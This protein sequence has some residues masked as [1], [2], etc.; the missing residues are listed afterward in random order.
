MPLNSER[1][2]YLTPFS[3]NFYLRLSKIERWWCFK[4]FTV[5]LTLLCIIYLY[6]FRSIKLSLKTQFEIEFLPPNNSG[7]KVLE[8][9]T[10]NG[11]TNQ[12]ESLVLRVLSWRLSG[13][14]VRNITPSWEFQLKSWLFQFFVKLSFKSNAKF[15]CTVLK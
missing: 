6:N 4:F 14:G 7:K 11:K 5:H 2:I 1:G 10:G 12:M 13:Q 8:K 15:T 3:L 9:Y